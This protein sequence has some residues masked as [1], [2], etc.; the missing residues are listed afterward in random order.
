MY[1]HYFSIPKLPDHLTEL[2]LSIANQLES[3]EIE[4]NK[5]DKLIDT[6]GTIIGG[7]KYQRYNVPEE[8][9]EWAKNNILPN[10]KNDFKIGIQVFKMIDNETTSYAIHTDGARG[11][12]VLNYIIDT[13]GN[14]VHTSWYQENGCDLYREPGLLRN[15]FQDMVLKHT[16]LL[17]QHTWSM[18]NSRILHTVNNLTRARISLSLGI[19][20]DDL[21]YLKTKFS[22][23]EI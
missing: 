2:A 14:Q 1:C 15:N 22:N 6:D 11:E 18:I 5:Y 13:G 4:F 17:E 8:I 20:A 21:V 23:Q 12:H 9:Y 7:S 10:L 16:L 3:A 19:S